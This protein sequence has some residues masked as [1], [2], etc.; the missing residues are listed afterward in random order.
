ML[1]I[2]LFH[3]RTDPELDMDEWGSDGPIFGPYEFVHTTYANYV[4]FGRKD[5]IRDELHV[6]E[7]D[8]LYYMRKKREQLY[9]RKMKFQLLVEAIEE[10]QEIW[11][12]KIGTGAWT[13]SLRVHSTASGI[14][15]A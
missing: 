8:M 10:V 14:W 5:E 2:R 12:K 15:L 3:G 11:L 13:H 9:F 7:K 6:R 4:R 1:Y